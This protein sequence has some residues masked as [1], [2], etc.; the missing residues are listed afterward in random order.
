MQ[1]VQHQDQRRV[2][3]DRAQEHRDAIEETELRFVAAG[4]RLRAFVGQR[5][6]CARDVVAVGGVAIAALALRNRPQQ[7][8]PGL[9]RGTA[10]GLHAAHEVD[11]RTAPVRHRR[12]F[13]GGA[14]LAD[15]G[16]AAEQHDAAVAVQHRVERLQQPLEQLRA[17]DIGAAGRGGDRIGSADLR[18]LDGSQEAQSARPQR[19]DVARV[20]SGVAERAAQVA[21]RR[22][23]G[24][25]AHA[26]ARPERLE[27]LALR[28]DPVAMTEQHVQ[29]LGRLAG[30]RHGVR[31]RDELASAGVELEAVEAEDAVLVRHFGALLRTPCGRAP[32]RK[33]PMIH[34]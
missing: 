15:P 28:H 25:V 8:H 2:V 33:T 12:E 3:R 22:R 4:G 32:A 30:D 11:L 20:P 6:Q 23:E 27:D 19:R 24:R 1:V 31:A 5:R 34:T 26:D 14:G 9:V 18:R 7:R 29:Q 10:S 13:L 17:P 16:L 21:Q